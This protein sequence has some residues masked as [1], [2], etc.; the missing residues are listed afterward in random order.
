MKLGSDVR[1]PT[2][3]D[4]AREGLRLVNA[5]IR[6]EHDRDEI[7]RHGARRLAGEAPMERD[8]DL[9]DATSGDIERLHAAGHHRARF[10]RAARRP[11]DEPS[12]VLDPALRGQLCR[13]SSG[14]LREV[15]AT[16][17]L[18]LRLVQCGKGRPVSPTDEARVTMAALFNALKICSTLSMIGAI[19]AEFFGGRQSALGV[20]IKSQ[21]G[22]L[23]LRE[24]WSGILMACLLGIAF[25]L[26]IVAAERLLMPWHVSFRRAR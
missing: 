14:S 22:L 24:C 21:A 3:N 9:V 18:K 15:D 26:V 23:R 13:E 16:R 17:L 8:A 25:Y 12:A 5:D 19:V 11:D 7:V 4:V 1:Q 2:G 6:L 20:Y 10:D